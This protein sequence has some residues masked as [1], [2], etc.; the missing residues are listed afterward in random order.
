MGKHL[1]FIIFT[2]MIAG[3]V[4]AEVSVSQPK[5]IYN[6][7]DEL[8]LSL[9]LRAVQNTEGFLKMV[10]SCE[11]SS[12]NI[13]LSPI[14]LN[15]NQDKIT[16]IN[17]TLSKSILA[18]LS[19]KCTVIITTPAGDATSQS[20]EITDRIELSSTL[21]KLGFGAGDQVQ[22]KG[23]MQ[24]PD[25]KPFSGFV[26]INLESTDISIIK[27]VSGNQFQINF[28]LPQDIRSG[29][30]S[31]YIKAYEKDKNGDITNQ[32]SEEIK[33]SI[34]KIP[35]KIE[36]SIASQSVIPGEDIS[37]KVF[38]YDQANDEV[39]GDATVIIK[40]P[41]N[42]EI[43]QR[44]EKT[45]ES[46]NYRIENNAT[47]GYWKIEASFQELTVKRLFYVE[48]QELA[49]FEVVGDMLYIRNIGNTPYRKAVQIAIGD[50]V[51]IKEM[52]LEVGEERRYR[53][54][55]PDGVYQVSVTD[56]KETITLDKVS[57]TGN[58]VGVVSE[59]NGNIF[60]TYPLVW[61]F[62]IIVFGMFVL[63][64]FE[65]FSDRKF[66]S[67]N[68]PEKTPVE[69]KKQWS[70]EGLV[71]GGVK[72]AEH[73][74][75]L[76]GHK[77]EA[78]LVAFKIKN[79]NELNDDSLKSIESLFSEVYDKK[80]VVY[81]TG[82]YLVIILTPSITKTF[83]NNTNAIKLAKSISEKLSVYNQKYA[84]KI[85]YGIGLNYGNIVVE[86]LQDKLKFASV[87][88]ALNFAKRIADI[89]KGEILISKDVNSHLGSDIKTEKRAIEGLDLYTLKNVTDRDNYQGF[90]QGFLDRNKQDFTKTI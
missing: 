81:K 1:A 27:P 38:M 88:N 37:F 69:I 28:T 74:I 22:V 29:T 18:G 9:S 80:G 31:L 52:E 55:A 51:E 42:D 63:M 13:Y 71:L 2:I 90:L 39:P 60:V 46:I 21:N 68:I 15:A 65:R 86:P 6:I 24:K 49:S 17:I 59:K 70:S 50:D 25:N 48:N 82:D 87:G 26:E 5:S 47:P 84:K 85:N 89:S 33:I 11:N 62:I 67:Y 4:Y 53:L 32:G 75:S 3:A 43:M 77:E 78:A 34:A 79:M 16:D 57:L 83:K 19:G 45:G 36:V 73:A 64:M 76:H 12:N 30:Y 10:L 41:E 54:V 58:V 56:G 40:D 66:I 35:Q 61:I 72:Q 8:S 23:I 14:S 7:G 44:L 20:F